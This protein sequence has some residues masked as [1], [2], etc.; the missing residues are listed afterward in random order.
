MTD[1]R[2]A[3]ADNWPPHFTDVFARRAK[4]LE[5]IRRD[6]QVRAAV[7]THYASNPV[8][9]ILDWGVTYD[10]RS[11]PTLMP[12]CLFPRQVELVQYLH[13]CVT[14]QENGLI[15]KCRDAGATWVASAYSVWLWLFWPGAAVGFGSRKEELVD[16]IGDPKTIFEKIR[17]L[18][19][20]LPKDLFWP[21][22][23]NPKDHMPF[24]KIINPENGA[25]IAGEAGDNIG[26]GGRCLI[27]FKDESAWYPRPESI[28]AALGDNTNVQI[29]IS[30][31]NGPGNVFYRRRKAGEVWTPNSTP[32]PGRTRVFIFDWRDDPRKND[33]WFQKRR[34]KAEAEGLIHVFNQEVLRDYNAA[35]ANVLIP[36]AWVDAAVGFCAAAG[37]EPTG[38]RVAGMDVAD[39]G[40]DVN[41]LAIRHGIE[42]RTVIS[43]GA[44]AEV[45]GRAMYLRAASA[46][47][48]EF[49]YEVNGVGAGA[50]AGAKQVRDSNPG[51]KMPAIRAWN[52]SAGVINPAGDIHTGETGPDV[53][54]RNRD[55]YAGYNAQ[56]W[57]ALRERF[58]KTYE[59]LN[60]IALHDFD[61][62]ISLPADL[63]N[64][65]TLKAEL[66]QPVWSQ[67]GAGKILVDKQPSGTKSPNLADA[68]KIA[69]APKKQELV[70]ELPGFGVGP[71]V[72]GEIG[73]A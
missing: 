51:R 2:I 69:Y 18:I 60:G 10:P 6:P 17:Q 13:S 5:T 41:A 48:G 40:A 21:K 56:S 1:H 9:W 38:E 70:D 71:S 50:R 59:V 45:A 8:D 28:E 30:S 37:I 12:F 19:N 66:S 72:P 35:V 24:M 14:D 31:V 46:R 42:L 62:L 34:A 53:E 32:T 47:C 4:L 7:L 11:K 3:T 65:E 73:F 29:D 20:F 57:W 64:L 58:R 49:W 23:F 54:R 22:G 15:E 36:G 63:E 55:H 16:R 61:D 43:Q 67:N 27:Y 25:T 39:G 52:P 26:R 33:A 68:V 44:E